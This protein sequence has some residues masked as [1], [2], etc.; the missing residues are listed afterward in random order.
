MIRELLREME[1]AV[2]AEVRDAVHVFKLPDQEANPGP[3]AIVLPDGARRA[4]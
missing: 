2:A 4:A 1:D 3:R